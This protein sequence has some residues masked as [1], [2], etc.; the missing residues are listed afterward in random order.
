MFVNRAKNRHHVIQ[1]QGG[2]WMLFVLLGQQNKLVVG[3]KGQ[4]LDRPQMRCMFPGPP[5]ADSPDILRFEGRCGSLVPDRAL[6][7]SHQV[8]EQV[9]VLGPGWLLAVFWLVFQWI[10]ILG[11][12]ILLPGLI[13]GGAAEGDLVSGCG[14]LFCST[15][16]LSEEEV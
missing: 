5:Q 1:P 16:P 4:T 7:R 6:V 11:F 8:A 2:Q 15:L 12:L 13:K 9:C 3:I 14:S 10:P